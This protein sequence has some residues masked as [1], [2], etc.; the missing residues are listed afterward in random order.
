MLRVERIFETEAIQ[1]ELDGYNPLIPDGNNLKATFMIEYEDATERQAALAKLVGIENLVW[2]RIGKAD[3]VWA[4]A[5][6]DIER[7]REGKTSA[8]HFLRFQFTDEM[9]RDAKAGVA[10]G[11]GIEHAEYDYRVEPLGEQT[12]DSLVADLV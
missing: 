9:V 8:V 10:I 6:E 5:D 2:A 4:I 1:E 11:I 3:R 12:R 7:S